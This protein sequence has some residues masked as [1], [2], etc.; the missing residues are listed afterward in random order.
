MAT[1]KTKAPINR[2]TQN[3]H[4][5]ESVSDSLFSLDKLRIKVVGVTPLLCANPQGMSKEKPKGGRTVAAKDM[6]PAEAARQAAYIDDDGHCCFPNVAL[7][8]CILDAADLMKIK[9]GEGRYPPSAATVIRSGMSFDYETK[10]AKLIHP[11]TGKPLTE[12]DY[13]VAQDRAVN[14][15]T[16]GAIIACRPRF[17]KW[18]AVFDLMIDSSNML[19]MSMIDRSFADILRYAGM[20]VGLGAWRAYVKPKGKASKQ[21]AGGPFG[22]FSGA[23]VD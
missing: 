8:S 7:Y 11:T 4:A 1:T 6:T 3:G 2:I 14:Q 21:S 19:L 22:K 12:A 15:N 23:I 17:D 5:A 13:Q 20:S 18:S 16:G 9:V 10:M